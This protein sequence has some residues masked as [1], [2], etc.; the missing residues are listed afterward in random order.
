M[1]QP[2]GDFPGG[3]KLRGHKKRS[4]QTP[5]RKTPLSRH[6]ILPLQQHIGA[7][8]VPVVEVGEKVLKGQRIARADGH[9]SVC[10]HAPSSGTVVAIDE[11]PIPHPSGLSAPCVTIETDGE[12]RWVE[13]HPVENY[14]D[15]S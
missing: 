12:A 3:L 9:V 11:Q 7:A 15:I 2:L 13:R 8:A 14:S 5:I 1:N 4:T 6:L 10:L